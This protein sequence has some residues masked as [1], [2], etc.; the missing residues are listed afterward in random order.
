[1]GLAGTI[2]GEEKLRWQQSWKELVWNGKMIREADDRKTAT[3]I[4]SFPIMMR[5]GSPWLSN[6]SDI[7]PLIQWKWKQ[8]SVK[9]QKDLILCDAVERK[10]KDR[11]AANT[12]SHTDTLL[13][14]NVWS[15]QTF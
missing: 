11:M 1:M 9:K 5:A 15:K 7:V 10:V 6:Y 14:G 3:W 12:V 13:G 8:Y 4:H 2:Q